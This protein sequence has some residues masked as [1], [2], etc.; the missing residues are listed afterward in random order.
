MRAKQS[1]L[2]VLYSILPRAKIEEAGKVLNKLGAM[3]S[4]SM[5]GYKANYSTVANLIGA[6]YDC[7]VLISLVPTEKSKEI[8]YEFFKELKLDQC[9]GIAFLTS[10]NAISKNTLEGCLE[11]F[12]PKKSRRR[13]TK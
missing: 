7:A 3:F 13:N 8:L 4:Y 12:K 2:K 1:P 5:L 6:D 9:D 10:I 11:F